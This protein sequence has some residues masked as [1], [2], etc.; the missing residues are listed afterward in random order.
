MKKL[1]F[2]SLHRTVLFA[3]T[4]LLLATSAGT[5][6]AER[7]VETW[8]NETLTV[9]WIGSCSDPDGYYQMT[10]VSTGEGHL[11]FNDN[12]V[13]H[14]W[15]ETGTFFVEPIDS[16]S[17]VTYSGQYAWHFQEG[18]NQNNY[19]YSETFQMVG[20]GSDGTHETFHVNA[21]IV[22]TPEGL[23]RVIDNVW[24]ACN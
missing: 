20:L 19:Y 5:A 14:G 24:W 6:F 22:E 3:L 4:L 11:I 8:H 18:I 13:K 9:G 1:R 12:G 2:H 16:I 7:I 15:S 17:P 10:I 21:H 23:V